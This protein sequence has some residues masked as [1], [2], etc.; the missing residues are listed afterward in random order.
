MGIQLFKNHCNLI[1]CPFGSKCGT[2]SLCPN[3]SKTFETQIY[4]LHPDAHLD[5][6]FGR[7]LGSAAA[8]AGDVPEDDRRSG[9]PCRDQNKIREIFRGFR[10]E[11]CD[12]YIPKLKI[13]YNLILNF[14]NKI[15]AEIKDFF[16]NKINSD[17]NY[18]YNYI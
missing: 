4:K 14:L 15:H 6:H 13:F 8:F 18:N 9:R 17:H 11:E 12:K 3:H 16:Y 5:G 7:A 2:S 1:V 10:S